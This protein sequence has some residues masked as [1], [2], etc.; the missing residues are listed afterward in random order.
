MIGHPSMVPTVDMFELTINALIRNDSPEN[1][2]EALELLKE[3]EMLHMEGNPSYKPSI[4]LYRSMIAAFKDNSREISMLL[5]QMTMLYDSN[6]FDELKEKN[7]TTLGF[8]EIFEIWTT[9]DNARS[10]AAS[11]GES[12][13]L[14]VAN[15]VKET[16]SRCSES[17]K[18][19]R[20][21]NFNTVIKTWLEA[22]KLHRAESLL[23]EMENLS[24]HRLLNDIKPDHLRYV[25]S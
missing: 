3:Q 10:D 4:K 7:S 15:G 13:L 24:K 16:N 20:T 17:T 11:W 18:I 25:H 1:T 19:L 22:G 8:S 2:R 23:Q 12:V 6:I 9:V 21:S 14:K 5:N